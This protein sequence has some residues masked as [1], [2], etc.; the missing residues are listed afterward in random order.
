MRFAVASKYIREQK[1]VSRFNIY[2]GAARPSLLRN[3]KFRGML[4]HL[5]IT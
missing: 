2:L 1:D 3:S 5:G 4:R